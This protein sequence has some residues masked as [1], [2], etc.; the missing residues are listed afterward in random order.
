MW[1]DH[2]YKHF[3]EY[4]DSFLKVVFTRLPLQT[5]LGEVAF[6]KE[7]FKKIIQNGLVSIFRY[8]ETD[9]PYLIGFGLNTIE[10][11]TATHLRTTTYYLSKS[12]KC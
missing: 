10:R 11:E 8:Q 7:I 2:L 5:T 9:W 6:I 3:E 1:I 12:L 4:E